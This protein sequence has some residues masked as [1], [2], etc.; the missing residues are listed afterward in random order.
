MIRKEKTFSIYTKLANKYN[1]PSRVV[2]VICNHPFKFAN[3]VISNNDDLKPIMF[4]YL[5]KIRPKRKVIK[6]YEANKTQ[7][8][9]S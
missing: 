5:F 4:T 1:I 7:S 6:E 9:N 8:R 3:S 2:E